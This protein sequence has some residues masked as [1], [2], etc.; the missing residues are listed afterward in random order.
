MPRT[1]PTFPGFPKTA[2]AFFKGIVRNNNKEWFDKNKPLYESGVKGPMA[3][4]VHAVGQG[5]LDYAPEYITDPKQ[6][7]YR[8]YRDIRFSKDKT[9]YKTNI[10]ASWFR[11]NLGKNETAGFYMQLDAKE[12]FIGAGIYMPM[13]DTLKALRAYIDVHHEEMRKILAGK[14]LVKLLGGLQGEPAARLPK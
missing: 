3:D 6:A 10:A 14:P 12:L 11:Q 9:P 7:I 5:M 8:I 4:L 2:Q 1:K 13:P